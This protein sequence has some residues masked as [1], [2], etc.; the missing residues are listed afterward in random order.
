MREPV[1]VIGPVHPNGRKDLRELVLQLVLLIQHF[2]V[3][4]SVPVCLCLPADED[5]ELD[6]RELL[7]LRGDVLGGDWNFGPL[8]GL[9]PDLLGQLHLP[10]PDQ[11]IPVLLRG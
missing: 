10:E 11:P 3:Q 6:L 4:P 5:P 1:P 2:E 8:P 9:Q 7:R